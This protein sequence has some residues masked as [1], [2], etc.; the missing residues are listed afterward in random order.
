LL[1]AA[2]VC[3]DSST[4]GGCLLGWLRDVWQ[5]P[6]YVAYANAGFEEV[7]TLRLAHRLRPKC[8][9]WSLPLLMAQVAV[10]GW[11]GIL[12]SS[13]PDLL[14]EWPVPSFP[15]IQS[16]GGRAQWMAEVMAWPHLVHIASVVLRTLGISFGVWLTGNAYRAQRAG[17][18]RVLIAASAAA[19]HLPV[20]EFVFPAPTP[21]SVHSSSDGGASHWWVL[22]TAVCAYHFGRRWSMQTLRL[23]GATN[24][25]ES[26]GADGR[27]EQSART[28]VAPTA[29][30]TLAAP[31]ATRSRHGICYRFLRY[32]VFVWV[33][34]LLLFSLAL[35]RL[36]DEDTGAPLK[37]S[38]KQWHSQPSTQYFYGQLHAAFHRQWSDLRSAGFTDY[39]RQLK[40][41]AGVGVL[42]D[43]L[44]TL[45]LDVSSADTVTPAQ[46]RRQRNQLALKFHPDKAHASTASLTRAQKDD[47]FNQIQQAYQTLQ[48]H[49]DQRDASN[50]PQKQTQ[51]QQQ[52]QQKPPQAVPAATRPRQKRRT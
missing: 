9:P 24:K 48:K 29:A 52:R 28:S 45:E 19:V 11:F 13:A 17:F 4:L 43:A 22:L 7:E 26:E 42:A 3:L 21:P 40:R 38:L 23:I 10:G 14:Q 16:A 50:N 34:W 15:T 44:H 2:L 49:I 5:L 12:A 1:S 46:L 41:Q 32:C 20:S 51:T 30:Y 31:I 25:N 39:W 27:A 33:F 37:V 8:P 36:N 6:S 18:L 35:T 47:K